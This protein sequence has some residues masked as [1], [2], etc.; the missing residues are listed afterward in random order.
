MRRVG[1]AFGWLAGGLMFVVFLGAVV[2]YLLVQT[3]PGHDF[4]LRTVLNQ[5]PRFVDGRVEVGGLRSDGLHRGFV[6]HDVAVRDTDGRPFVEADSLRV[7]YRFGDLLAGAIGVGPVEVW[8]PRVVLETLHGQDRSN[9]ERI[10]VPEPGPE[11]DPMDEDLPEDPSGFAVFLR[12]LTIHD[13]LFVLRLPYEGES[14][15]PPAG[16][17]EEID[18]VE[19][20][21]LRFDFSEIQGRFSRLDLLRPEVEGERI[22]VDRL[23]LVG[24][25]MAEPFVV[26][27]VRGVIERS[28]PALAMEL[29]RLWLPGTE[30]AG[31]IRMSWLDLDAGL[32]LDV[33]MDAPV[34]QLADLQWL[35]PRI[36]E[37]EGALALEV[38][39]RLPE[40]RWRIRQADLRVGDSRVQG[41]VGLDLG[42]EL[43]FV[44]VDLQADPFHLTLL[45]PWLPEPLPV[46]GRLMGRVTASGP[47]RALRVG[48]QV[49]WDDPVREI[50]SSTVEARGL[51][52]LVE[53]FGV[54]DLELSVDPLRYGTLAA[55]LPDLPVRGEGSLTL[56]ASGDMAA[57][58]SLAATGTHRPDAEGPTSTVSVSGQVTERPDGWDLLL[59]AL[60][61][62]L[63]LDGVASALAMELPLTGDVSG[64]VE[65]TGLLEDLGVELDVATAAGQVA[66][67]GRVNALDPAAG[68]EAR[69][70]LGDFALH[71]LV[72]DAP[73]PTIVNGSFD[74]VGSGF[75][76]DTVEGSATLE[77]RDLLVG[78]AEV[79]RVTARLAARDGILLVDTLSLDS[80]LARIAGTGSLGLREGA[81][82]G[83]VRVVWEVESMRNLRPVLLGEEVAAGDTLT[84]IDRLDLQFQGIDPDTLPQ[85]TPLDGRAQGELQLRGNAR[86]FTGEGSIRLGDAVYGDVAVDDMEGEFTGA[87]RG[88]DAWSVEGRLDAESLRFG[89]LSFESLAVTGAYEPD[90]GH[91]E[92][93][94]RRSD[95][96][97]YRFAGDFQVE[98]ES[99]VADLAEL[100]LELDGAQW[101][102]DRPARLR[103]GAGGGEVDLLRL[104][105]PAVAGEEELVDG[106]RIEARGR[107]SLDGESDF[108]V[109]VEGA[110]I[111]RLSGILQVSDPPRG[112]LDL[113]LDVAGPY[114][115]PT[116]AG[117]FELREFENGLTSVSRL[118][119]SLDYRDLLATAELVVEVNGRRHLTAQGRVPMDLSFR[120]VDDRFPDRSL[121][122]DLDLDELPA[123]T[124]LAFLEVLEDVDGVLDGQIR[125]RGTPA[126]LRPSGQ[127]RLASGA[128]AL[129]ELGLRIGGIAGTL[130]IRED[131]TVAV[132]AEARARGTAR[133]TGTISLEDPVD[134]AF[135]LRIQASNFQ[136][137]DR[138]DLNARVGG[139]VTLRGRYTSPQVGGNVRVDQGNIFIE[140]FARTAEV[141]DLTDPDFFNVVDTMLV[142]TRPALEAAQNP[143][144][145]NLRV[146]VDLV[147]QRDFWLRS[148]EMN[149]EMGG[150]LAVTFDRAQREI[151][152]AG[153]LE[154]IRG[155]YSA[156]GRQFQ[157]R[158]GVVEFAGTPG[159][160]PALNIEAVH[161]LR[162]EGGEPL[163]I[164]ANLGGTLMNLRVE[165]TS[166]SQ[167]PIAESDLISYLVFGRPSYALA[168]GE[169]SLLEG[170]AGVG[171]S[172]GVGVIGTQLGQ[173]VA[174]QLG[175]DFFTIT[176]TR[177]AGGLE[178]AAGFTGAFA[179][180]QIEVGQYVA[181]NLF[182]A[183]VLRP[184]TGLGAQAQ[185]QFPGARLE[186]R[187]TDLWTL[188]GFVED[189][190]AREAASGFGQLGLR[191]DKVLGFSIYREWG[192]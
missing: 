151:V 101:S 14:D 9:V 55:F 73:D 150:E 133:V 40:S 88:R 158:E 42:E 17:L 176:Q 35:E 23:S 85:P 91:A 75:T 79:E 98:P 106:A 50:P 68:V 146:D 166:D 105:R 59:D 19:G 120:T 16:A 13:G 63:S 147:L 137:V 102:L 1:R 127:I 30:L 47:L 24:Q 67:R 188:E 154:A 143:F 77:L 100:R 51:L 104:T 49:T 99:V 54:A 96:Q 94:L 148:Q 119:G 83:E 155:A 117:R 139:T 172:A 64:R 129:P 61:E 3:R 44:D 186:W 123:A 107:I 74:V 21:H 124:A 169:S 37:G 97:A 71:L 185:N 11:P 87:F 132:E 110:D 41:Q 6:L 131:R 32:E 164:I 134:P 80:P 138:R 95:D 182:L 27:D 115:A 18:G 36:P 72:P 109:E 159:V 170:A 189:R 125:V 126:D 57:G 2:A 144:L 160:D 173:V 174:Q 15:T 4:V 103:V 82:D 43:R 156:F 122:I 76:L 10:F 86:D 22:E 152:M 26:D 81:G 187:F 52:A 58:F 149:V 183:L 46:E 39:G 128:M 136:A 181:D 25:V 108:R 191:L 111:Q 162:R 60:L 78:P 141:V 34:L 145:Q 165:L 45:D 48:G 135:D 140:E 167:P 20:L 180:T 92:V 157:V 184:L 114:D 53:P 113:A 93:D 171:V 179:G 84:D 62:P 66:A 12:D 153:T 69:G 116:I 89:E 161:R 192:Y 28:G 8:R 178:Q 31:R 121:E 38:R 90:R 70:E 142:A 175:I 7:R 177:E 65:V 118:D 190:F 5:A 56:S 130:D 163:E 29:D 33:A 112:F 168:S